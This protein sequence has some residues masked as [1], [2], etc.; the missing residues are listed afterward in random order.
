MGIKYFYTWI[1][2]HFNDCITHQLHCPIDTMAIDMNG[3]FHSSVEKLY[4]NPNKNYII[5]PNNSTISK[6]NLS[7][8]KEICQRIEQLKD[9]IQPSKKIL[10][11]VDGVAGLGKINQ[12][13]QRRYR[14]SILKNDDLFDT[15]SFTPGTKLMDYLTKYIDWYLRNT[16]TYNPLWHNLEII[17]SNEKVQGEGEHKIIQYLKKNAKPSESICIIGSD[18]DLILL[19]LLLNHSN[20]YI[21][22][23]HRNENFEYIHIS[24]LKQ[25]LVEYLKWESEYQRVDD[26]QFHSE[27]SIYDF[28]FITFFIG[29]DF[30]P[31]ISSI[32]IYDGTLDIILKLYQQNAKKYGNLIYRTTTGN[33]H[34]QTQALGHF[35]IELG[36]VEKEFLENKYNSQK[37][38]FPDPL[39]IK[40]MF[41]IDDKY[42]L[43]F[44]KYRLE[45][46]N[47]K[48]ENIPITD[49]VKMYVDGMI[50]TLL[51]YD[52]GIPDW[53]WF[54]TYSYAPLLV[55]FGNYI[56]TEYKYPRFKVNDLIPPFF[57][58]LLVIPPSSSYL[59]PSPLN[60]LLNSTSVLG[61]YF[62]NN[63][64][65][66]LTG[67]DKEWEG[68]VK[69]PCLDYD[70]FKYHYNIIIQEVNS[71]D[72][73]RNIQGKNFNYVYD[74]NKK[75]LFTSFYGSIPNC[76]IQVSIF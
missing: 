23:S 13:R 36:R 63:I 31:S 64:E 43:N 54:Y 8:F 70:L 66:D 72:L 48:F 45:Y 57:Q 29:N 71:I 47:Q 4:K 67:K 10:L 26:P 62:P 34:I 73:K 52:K 53:T 22:R 2:Q 16:M 14:T 74:P 76:P 6:N 40:N 49:I 69:L 9:R 28:V 12:Q 51:Y 7:L 33:L 24:K 58:L 41:I 17:F 30:L 35:F 25:K 15:N 21:C 44:D 39:I 59:L 75:V 1:K 3:L 37:S 56:L 61:K 18:A 38:F 42:V 50:W 46:Y 20:I 55:D 27:Y 60:N 11:C 65:I 32:N 68:I 19:C 5:Q